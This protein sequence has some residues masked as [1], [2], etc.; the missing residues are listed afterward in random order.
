[1]VALSPLQRKAAFASAVE[2]NE[3]TKG[4]AAETIGVT[5]T[6]LLLCMEGERTPSVELAERVA[7]YVGMASDEFW[8]P[9]EAAT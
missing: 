7:R 8:G 4:G 1:M 2:L 6:H 9:R 3:T 5:W